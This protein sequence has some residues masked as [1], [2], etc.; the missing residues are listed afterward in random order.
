MTQF[1]PFVNL[2]VHSEYSLIDG[3][4]RIP[5]AVKAAKQMGQSSLAVTDS[6]VLFGAIEFYQKAKAE[7]IKPIFGC[8]IYFEGLTSTRKYRDSQANPAKTPFHL[9]LLAKSKQGFDALSRIS[10]DSFMNNLHGVPIV[11][12]DCLTKNNEDL[13]ALSGDQL[14]ELSFLVEAAI[15]VAHPSSGWMTTLDWINFFET[16]DDDHLTLPLSLPTRPPSE[17]ALLR[18]SLSEY[19]SFVTQEFPNGDFFVELIDNKLPG[20]RPLLRSLASLAEHFKL[21]RVCSGDS[22]Y[23]TSG[24]AESHSVLV[25]IKSGLTMKDLRSRSKKSQF[26]LLSTEEANELYGEWP[27]ALDNTLVVADKCN[28]LFEF[29]K[30]YL[31]KFS[32]PQGTTESDYMERIAQ[33]MLE[34]RLVQLAK[35]YGTSFDQ[36]AQNL[37]RERLRYEISVIQ[38]MGFSGYFLI[39][40]DFI[41][42]AKSK[43]I[44]V[45]PGRGSGVGSLVA[46]ALRITDVDPIKLNLL[47]ERFL[48]PERI[49][50]PDFDVDF[51]QDRRHEVIEYVTQKYG[52]DRVAQI[53]TFGKMKA[54]LAIRDVG[55]V[56]E[57][58][59]GRVDRIAKL[60]PN[61]V[62]N[63][64]GEDVEAT[65]ASAVK[66]EPRIQE[67]AAK[68]PI[69]QDLLRITGD[70]EGLNRQTGM[71]AAGIV[72]SDGPMTDH[73][74]VF[75]T[76]EG[77]MVTQYEMK[78][79]E[80]I[81][82]VKFDF[83]G[84]KTL[85]VIQK[86]IEYIHKFRNPS[87]DLAS[88]NLEDKK[89]YEHIST[90]HTIGIFQLEGDGMMKLVKKLQP[91]CFE[92]VLALV[93]LFRPGPLGSGMV[94]DFV[95]RKHGRQVI[96]YSLP[97]LEPILRETY[98]VILY[99]E[100]VQ[101]IAVT[102]AN[103][104]P[105]EADLLR[106]AM[107]K[108]DKDVMGKQ[109]IRF[110][111][112]AKSNNHSPELSGEIFDLM[113]KFAEYGFNKSHSA[114]YGLIAYQTAFLKTHYPDL[115][116]AAIMSCDLDDTDK[117]IRYAG[118]CVRLKLKLLGPCINESDLEFIVT[119]P[120]K[121]RWGLSGIKGIGPGSVIS[122]IEERKKNGPFTCIADLVER[123][124]LLKSVGKKTL[125]ILV[126]VGALDTFGISRLQLLAELGSIVNLS[127][128]KHL[129]KA[130][131]RRSLFEA[132][133]EG[134]DD[135][136]ADSTKD[137]TDFPIH[138]RSSRPASFSANEKALYSLAD[139]DS[140]KQL[141]GSYISGH[142]L[143]FFADDVKTFSRTSI[144]DSESLAGKGEF[145]L[146][147]IL[148]AA[149]DRVTRTGK[150]IAFLPISDQTG[151]T[152]AML[153][154]LNLL[155]SLPPPG[156]IS[157][158]TAKISKLPDGTFTRLKISKVLPIEELRTTAVKAAKLKFSLSEKDQTEGD[159][160][161]YLNLLAE[162]FK[163][164]PGH[165]KV[166]IDLHF[167]KSAVRLKPSQGVE[168]SNAFLQTLRLLPVEISYGSQR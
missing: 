141:L 92:D 158:V 22:H 20:Q 142:P 130:S 35:L 89:V 103:Y 42:W 108:K 12:S 117:M 2:H 21:P 26:H 113:A 127:E 154:D 57:L 139:L 47:F 102:L 91:S 165:T 149:S 88:I 53:A 94:D 93:A 58:S 3:S 146:V 70:L 138:W 125:E 5:Q 64:A 124:S 119:E 66:H 112:G 17:R 61:K 131:G 147:A 86:A 129:D 79:A 84:L 60:I 135:V 11:T 111:E 48:N 38:K 29:G 62:P 16:S 115:F 77:I 6:G 82:L 157:I 140:E 126:K 7:G 99:Q 63:E 128:T 52:K 67:E 8:E 37:Y 51:C 41:N 151:Q 145:Q 120:A 114:A 152:D 122:M 150:R 144:R 1:R 107:G 71:H 80:K 160:H 34:E 9:L 133:H 31:P 39:V 46:Y 109:R 134:D 4:I 65:I 54:K 76:G 155:G 83:L 143:N 50:M 164:A 44:P 100:Q 19:I 40:Q 105:G 69:I 168:L 55:R 137:K 81:G 110:L 97:E 116:M 10:S 121:I 85:T 159:H 106:R 166:V 23:L 136:G 18:D 161:H 78:N 59:Y 96:Q 101:K 148:G 56:L 156:S 27:D 73:A 25:A 33:E 132:A 90:A 118:D 167:G 30:Y 36:A 32:V 15:K 98:G 14:G 74:P 153:A 45:G 72:M 13:I 162:A 43:G 68:D 104:T 123:V 28:V 75:T 24:F 87:F 95:E 163:V 49:S